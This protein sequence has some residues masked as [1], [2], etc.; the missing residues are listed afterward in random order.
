MKAVK[1]FTLLEVMLVLVILAATACLVMMSSGFSQGEQR[2]A[3]N[4]AER[5]NTQ[6]EYAWD[7]ATYQGKPVG[8]LMTKQG[9]QMLM[10]E[11]NGK[12][13]TLWVPLVNARKQIL[14][15]EWH[16]SWLVT[17]QPQGIAGN[18]S[19]QIILLPDGEITPFTLQIVE[20]EERT[21]LITIQS[22]GVLPLAITNGEAS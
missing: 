21:P 4:T 9:W 19:P 12:G 15:G 13:K 10:M 11:M 17:L 18:S 1:G 20:R 14:N 22:S 5:L 6:L 7:W 3:A 8:I 2:S 16:D